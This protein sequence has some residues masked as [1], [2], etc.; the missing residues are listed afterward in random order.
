MT[1]YELYCS[2]KSAMASALA[3]NCPYAEC[4]APEKDCGACAFERLDHEVPAGAAPGSTDGS[5][6]RG[7][8]GLL[9]YLK[10]MELDGRDAYMLSA[11]WLAS[12]KDPL[13]C[14]RED[15][16]TLLETMADYTNQ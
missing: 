12:G 1:Y 10:T 9:D 14:S 6:R 15:I 8:G 7:I 2:D 16:K 3:K 13:L 4:P 11:G 5:G